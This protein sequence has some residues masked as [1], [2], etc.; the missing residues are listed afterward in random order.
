MGLSNFKTS[1]LKKQCQR[2][3]YESH[4]DKKYLQK[5]AD[6]EP[7]LYKIYKT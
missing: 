6:K 2:R 3:E 1:I 7:K 4:I 5:T